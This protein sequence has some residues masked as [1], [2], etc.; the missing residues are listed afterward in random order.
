[1]RVGLDTRLLGLPGI[2]RFAQ[3]LWQALLEIGVDVVG[4]GAPARTEWLG[5][6]ALEPIAPPARLDARPHRVREQA[7]LPRVLARERIDVYHSPHLTVPY[8][9][10][11]P[12]VLTVHDLLPLR[13]KSSASSPLAAA[14]L[15]IVFPVAM[16][17]AD[18]LVADAEGTADELATRFP[19][20]ASKVSVVEPGIDLARWRPA[21][22]GQVARVRERHH[23]P[24]RYLLYVGTAKTHKNLDTLLAA[25][26][27]TLPPL[28]I[29][30]ASSAEIGTRPA[31]IQVLG[32]VGDEDLQALYTGA[33]AV[34]QPSRAEAVGLTALEAMACDTPIVASASGGLE[35]TVGDAA[36][37][38]DP[39]DVG[40]WRRALHRMVE[41]AAL[42]EALIAA[43]RRRVAGRRWVDAA[44]KYLAIYERVAVQS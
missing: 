10:R 5:D 43:G 3:G 22:S 36:L 32:R 13:R 14:Y 4:L 18:A 42:R 23:L 34:A 37:L 29:A 44:R 11:V 35:G 19:A 40:A 9:S 2:G 25:H 1:M 15:R 31:H 16:R 41:D 33:L 24:D 28:V 30:G 26:D 21:T 20:L 7:A 27:A 6:E 12:V 8:L 38:A 17:H 39:D